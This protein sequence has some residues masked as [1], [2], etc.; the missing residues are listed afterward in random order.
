MKTKL[1]IL[2]TLI[3]IICNAQ[4]TFF[5]GKNPVLSSD[6]TYTAALYSV[7]INDIYVD[8]TIELV[9][10][11]NLKRLSFYSSRETYVTI[12]GLFGYWGKIIGFRINDKINEDQFYGTSWGWDNVRVGENYYYTMV[13]KSMNNR[14]VPQ[15][16]T[17][18]KLYDQSKG[19]RGFSFDNYTLYNPHIGE[20]YW[21]ET[22]I[23]DYSDKHNDG[24]CGIYEGDDSNGYKL[25][26]IQENGEY[27]LIYLGG[28]EK[29][30]WWWTGD[31]KAI[32]RPSA[33]KGFFKA[34][35]YMADKSIKND[36][37]VSFDGGCMNTV[38]GSEKTFYLKMY[39]TTTPSQSMESESSDWSG[40]GFAL[41]NGYVVTNYH[42]VDGAKTI[43]VQGIQ[44]LFAISYNA[45]VIATDKTND[46]A[47]I[48]ISDSR[49]KG[50]GKI[51]Y[52]VK[53]AVSEVGEDVFVLGYP[54]TSTMGD[55]IKLTTGV[56][57]SRTG[58]QGDVSLY[59]ISAPI[60]PGNSGGP[61]FDGNGN[62]IGIVNAKH[63]GA[64][65]V[66]YAIKTSYL[67][68]LVESTSSASLLPTVNTIAGMSLSNKVKSIKNFVFIIKCSSKENDISINNQNVANID[69]NHS[70]NNQ[71][72]NF[73]TSEKTIDN[74]S[75]ERRDDLL[76]KVE[77]IVLNGQYTAVK[78]SFVNTNSVWANIDKNTYISANG[79]HYTLTKADDIQI[80]PDITY[81]IPNKKKIFWL[82]FPPIPETATS[83]DLIEPGDSDW[84]LYGIKLQ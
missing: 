74:P 25:G 7:V 11:R 60:Q 53:T 73:R 9:P 45:T 32:L 35:W 76:L 51:P 12:D 49:F 40:T 17:N 64:E 77:K 8:V 42:V 58:F 61:L 27:K 22:S 44:G 33:T 36:C 29:R 55:E 38:V 15:G 56:I 63:T 48:K 59:Q 68:N 75:I 79:V 46:L 43:V 23:K 71:T 21:T 4:T 13:F 47:I 41:N 6:G 78:L 50:F 30:N 65:N 39:P 10:T 80:A 83:I 84:K 66:S 1:L 62:L 20:T 28:K 5:N 24:I 31:L 18:F 2:F 26:C 3:S 16:A 19:K 14:R 52:R 57:S 70:T 54:L 37:Y 81:L 82:Y 69:Y 72:N 67:N 34:D